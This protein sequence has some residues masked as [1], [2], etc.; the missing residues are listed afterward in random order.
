MS[1]SSVETPMR[2]EPSSNIWKGSEAPLEE[3]ISSRVNLRPAGIYTQDDFFGAYFYHRM[4]GI[5]ETV[6]GR[7]DAQHGGPG[8]PELDFQICLQDRSPIQFNFCRTVSYFI[9]PRYLPVMRATRSPSFS[10]VKRSPVEG[11]WSGV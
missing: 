8:G 7:V 5:G 9:R 6:G 3:V 11:A 10:A 2:M 1:I 4:V